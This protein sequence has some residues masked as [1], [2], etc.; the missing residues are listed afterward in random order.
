MTVPSKGAGYYAVPPGADFAAEFARGFYRRY[1]DLGVATIARITVLTNTARAARQIEEALADYAREAGPLPRIALIDQ[2]PLGAATASAIPE[3]VE[4]VRRQLRLTRLV[5]AYL[6][7]RRDAGDPTAPISA[8]GDLAKALALL[9]DQFHDEAIVPE[10]LDT[11]IGDGELG[12]EAAEHWRRSLKFIDIVRSAWPLILAENE[13]GAIDPRAYQTAAVEAQIAA[14]NA[15]PPGAPIIAAATTGSVASTARLLQAIAT[16]PRGA[17]VLPGFAPETD[18]ELWDSVTDDHPLGPFK[19]WM[20]PLDLRPSDV[21]H[22]TETAAT[23]RQ[24][25][26]AQ[27]LRPAPVTDHWHADADAL[28]GIAN[29]ALDGITLVEAASPAEEAASIALIMRERLETPEQKVTLI[30]PDAALSRRVTAYLD[31]LNIVPDDTSGQPLLKSPPAVLLLL[32]AD[33]AVRRADAVGV[34]A[35]LLHPLVQP[36]MSRSEHLDLARNYELRVLRR[37]GFGSG[38]TSL[39]A[40]E[41][42]SSSEALEAWRHSINMA[43]APLAQALKKGAPLGDILV[44]HIEA[45][46]KL[47]RPSSDEDPEAA[48][49]IWA[50]DG[51]RLRSVLDRIL[52]NTDAYGEGSIPDYPILLSTLLR[53]ETIRPRLREP[54]PRVAIRGPREARIDASDLVI[55]AGLNEGTWPAAPD[56][57]PWLS[58][59]MHAALGLPMPERTVGLSAHDFQQAACRPNV[60]LTRSS[61]VDGAPTVAS[62][63][64]TRLETL[65]EGIGARKAWCDVRNRGEVWTKLAR[66]QFDAP[67]IEPAPRPRPVLDAIPEPREI[68]VTDVETLIR[69][70]YAIYAKRILNLRPLD[71]LNRPADARERG[72]VLHSVMEHVLDRTQTWPGIESAREIFETVA[73][74]VLDEAVPWPDLRRV[75]RSRILRFADWFVAAEEERRATGMPVATERA[76]RMLIDLPNGPF[77]IRAKADRID[78]LSDGTAAIYDYKSGRPPSKDEI[79]TFSHQLHLQA[80]ILAAGGF[81]DLPRLAVSDGAYIGMAGGKAGGLETRPDDLGDA[82]GDYLLSLQKLLAEFDAGAPWVSLGRPHRQSYASDYDHLARRAEWFGEDDA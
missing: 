65:V 40:S 63:W 80:A 22:W 3:P 11:V 67:A 48:P 19:R 34:S 69:D 49:A 27:A 47:T 12:E 6:R 2:L 24:K 32:V 56:A 81:E 41:H 33:L 44:R 20:G 37:G 38:D 73:D 50:E 74:E 58:R 64:V 70:A 66:K 72:N 54:H 30:T 60:V 23:T 55:L 79:G 29:D 71:P 4:P 9:I 52:Q 28:L 78:R 31:G 26:I 16:L 77:E 61:K 76:G 7:T 43:I 68:S 18:T 46:E 1:A 75:W 21:Q 39:P 8:A 17:V 14:W 45:L 13:S 5:E 59:P 51:Q 53:G 25:L 82:S 35:L 42:A 36:G 10:E 15:A 57:G 62:R